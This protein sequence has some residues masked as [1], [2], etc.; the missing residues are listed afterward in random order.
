MKYIIQYLIL[1][2][3]ITSCAT[4]ASNIEEKSNDLRVAHAATEIKI[5][6]AEIRP[7]NYQIHTKGKVFAKQ[8][9]ALYPK[10]AGVLTSLHVKTGDWVKKGA[11][12]AT[13]ENDK[14]KIAL[15]KA[16]V[17]LDKSELAFRNECVSFFSGS[18]LDDSTTQAIRQTLMIRKGVP[19]AKL[20]VE[21]AQLNLSYTR[22]R[23]NLSGVIA[24]LN[25]KVGNLL[26]PETA[27]CTLYYP[28]ELQI[29][30]Q[31]LESEVTKLSVGQEAFVTTIM[32]AAREYVTYISEINPVVNPKTGMVNVK[33]DFRRGV[34]LLPGMNVSAVIHVPYQSNLIVPKEALLVRSGKQVVF[35]EEEGLAKWKYVTVGK[36]NHKEIEILEG[37]ATGDKV[38]IVNNLQ[39]AHDSP[40]VYADQSK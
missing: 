21:E 34:K 26:K 31:V 20:Q 23:A 19:E 8:T 10:V 12:L 11:L 18:H 1:I 37:L 17:A 33:L 29:E 25:I 40:V 5:C 24:D 9:M 4:T 35:V 14:Q 38:I 39:L 3:G 16:K 32:D 13:I 2:F 27:F 7:F 28:N 6:T 30:T 22:I 15:K 36:E